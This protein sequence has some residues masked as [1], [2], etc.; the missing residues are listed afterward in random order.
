MRTT[1][2]KIG[3]SKGIIIPSSFLTET[4]LEDSVEMSLVDHTIVIRPALK[5][6]REDWY[7]KYHSHDDDDAWH[8]FVSL[9]SEEDEWEW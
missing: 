5:E 7:T 9:P 3:N 6:L 8:G 1:I 4:G 2:R